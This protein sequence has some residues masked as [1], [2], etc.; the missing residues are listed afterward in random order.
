[1]SAD[2]PLFAKL[3]RLTRELHDAVT[4]LRLDER[5]ARIAGDEMPDARHRLDYVI[6]MTEKAAHRTLDLV[7][8]A[9]GVADGIDV[10]ARHIAEAESVI[11]DN[12]PDFGNVSVLLHGTGEDL[13]AQSRV[14]RG[15]LSE[16]AQAQEYQ[17]LAGQIIKRVI[18]LVCT[19][20]HSLLE[21]LRGADGVGLQTPSAQPIQPKT[22]E[23]AGPAVP[24]TVAASQ[25]DADELLASLGF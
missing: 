7:E 12:H 1:M 18:A 19:V 6:Q 9:R 17:D 14:L 23:L 4:Q 20:E 25:Q 3:A 5:L 22:G 11:A 2:D 24:G 16:L 10:A 21:L 8:Q 15:T 13:R